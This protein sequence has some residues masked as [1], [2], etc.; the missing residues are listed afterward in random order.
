MVIFY[1]WI[2]SIAAAIFVAKEKG[3]SYVAAVLL[4][5]FLGPVGFLIVCV[6][7][8]ESKQ[9]PDKYPGASLDEVKKE[10]FRIKNDA[11]ALSRNIGRL[12][13][14]LDEM[15]QKQSKDLPSGDFA[16]V[17][18]AMERVLDDSLRDKEKCAVSGEKKENFEFVFGKYWLNRIG[19]LIF[20]AGVGFF[21]NYAFG[22]LT[23]GLKV[24]VGYLLAGLFFFC[25]IHLEKSE[26]FKRIGW[27]ILGGAWG[28][29]YLVTYAMY[30]IEFT[31]V[32]NSWTVELLLLAAVSLAAVAFSLKYRQWVVT[33]ITYLLAFFTAG[34]AGV[35]YSTIAYCAFLSV[36]VAFLAY[37]LN[38]DKFLLCGIAGNFLIYAYWLR[39]QIFSGFLVS[40][41]VS[42]PMYQF[43]LCSGIILVSWFI[44][45]AALL[46]QKKESA[47][48]S[49]YIFS[50]LLVNAFFVVYLGLHETYYFM[51]RLNS[52]FNL[53]FWYL[54][55][56]AAAYAVFALIYKLRFNPKLL[57]LSVSL[58][59]SLFTMALATS[60]STLPITLFWLIELLL[61]FLLVAYYKERSY[62]ALLLILAFL[63]TWRMLIVDFRNAEKFIV[64]GCGL[65]HNLFIFGFAGVIFYALGLL[66]GHPK[67]KGIFS[68]SESNIYT[69]LP[70]FVTVVFMLL[71]GQEILEKWL[72]LVWAIEGLAVLCVGLLGNRKVYRLC[73]LGVLIVALLR[74][75]IWDMKGVETIYRVITF[76][77]FGASL[78]GVSFAYSFF[79][80]RK[81]EK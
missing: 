74:L 67:I 11:I 24:A 5:L 48:G 76:I 36:S 20:V 51:P 71:L 45:S 40:S 16:P 54:T 10:V 61:I 15:M 22:A 56:L 44:F 41:G 57:V 75:F 34:L 4:P 80:G 77:V 68:E 30:Y 1:L 58:A 37:R 3:V 26:R 39:E 64:L 19:V 31:R 72:T 70:V 78:I 55:F 79:T 33:A 2:I 52:V 35:D 21:A 42:F 43:Q 18:P 7:S 69:C 59:L 13:K 50:A 29:I 12:E 47:D 60:S 73:G 63:C 32:I 6:M 65:K 25:G 81:E 28:L 46:A 53:P 8:P 23:A 49:K 62:R 66:S 9:R 17:T 14:T 38:W 27:G